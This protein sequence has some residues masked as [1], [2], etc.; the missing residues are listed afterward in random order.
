MCE[1]QF[2]NYCNSFSHYHF[3]TPKDFDKRIDYDGKNVSKIK[4][5]RGLELNQSERPTKYYAFGEDVK[6]SKAS[7]YLLV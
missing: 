5:E 6:K 2:R 3:I 4:F 7:N 1:S